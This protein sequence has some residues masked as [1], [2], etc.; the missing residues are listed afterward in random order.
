MLAPK[1]PKSERLKE[2]AGRKME[3]SQKLYNKAEKIMSEGAP[4]EAVPPSK[5]GY[6]V[7]SSSA[8]AKDLALGKAED[9]YRRSARKESRA[10]ALMDKAKEYD[11]TNFKNRD[12]DKL[13][14]KFNFNVY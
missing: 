14:S 9:L 5:R 10:K 6:G 13:K 4:R 8:T 12:I 11:A 2:R 3:K 1:K 7:V